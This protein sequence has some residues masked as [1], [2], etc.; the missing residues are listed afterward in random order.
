MFDFK[1]IKIWLKN[2]LKLRLNGHFL[3]S[4]LLKA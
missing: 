2:I 3:G 1:S 4:K